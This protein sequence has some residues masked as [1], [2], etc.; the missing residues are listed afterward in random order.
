MALE[1][2]H[3]SQH[4]HDR[5]PENTTFMIFLDLTSAFDT[6]DHTILINRL[7]DLVS[8]SGL[9]LEWFQSHLSNRSFS[10]FANQFMLNS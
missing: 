2:A 7:Q 6:G 8:V 9:A 5:K 3:D 10:D 4:L 1:A